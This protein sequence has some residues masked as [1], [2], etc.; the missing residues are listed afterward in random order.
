[1]DKIYVVCFLL[2]CLIFGVVASPLSGRCWVED[3]VE[4][5]E[6]LPESISLPSHTNVCEEMFGCY[7]LLFNSEGGCR[8]LCLAR[9]KF[10]QCQSVLIQAFSKKAVDQCYW[11]IGINAEKLAEYFCT[12]DQGLFLYKEYM[13][14]PFTA[15]A[16][17]M[18]KDMPTKQVMSYM[19]SMFGFVIMLVTNKLGLAQNH[20]TR[21]HEALSACM[22]SSYQFHQHQHS[23]VTKYCGGYAA[24]AYMD[25]SMEILQYYSKTIAGLQAWSPESNCTKKRDEQDPLDYIVSSK[26]TNVPQIFE[27]MIDNRWPVCHPFNV[28]VRGLHCLTMFHATSPPFTDVREFFTLFCKHERIEHLWSCWKP[29][30]DACINLN[31]K[32]LQ[33]LDDVM[34]IH[35]IICD[36]NV[37]PQTTVFIERWSWHFLQI[38]NCSTSIQFLGMIRYVIQGYSKSSYPF[39]ENVIHYFAVSAQ[40][41]ANSF[42]AA[43]NEGIIKKSSNFEKDLLMVYVIIQKMLPLINVDRVDLGLQADYFEHREDFATI[44][45]IMMVWVMNLFVVFL[46]EAG[47]ID[48]DPYF[49]HLPSAQSFEVF[50]SN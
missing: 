49:F 20:D 40:C 41:L 2:D 42:L 6:D 43:Y 45:V 28:L 9:N 46:G 14:C 19:R 23:I 39:D 18:V 48:Y 5:E 10:T 15:L 35:V 33:L 29:I 26:F 12:S 17:P 11:L 36:I 16:I 8:A 34:K 21:W 32:W 4:Q 7:R 1:M 25:I 44:A 22:C 50:W 38:E 3:K 31:E 27:L 37:E 13:S 47:F 30:A 24:D